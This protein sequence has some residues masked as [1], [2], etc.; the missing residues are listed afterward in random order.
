M[1]ELRRLAIGAL[2]A[3]AARA[4]LT[5]LILAKLRSDV[6]RLNGGD[7]AP[8][9]AGYADD[10]VLHFNDG[11]HRCAGEFRGKPAIEGFLRVF[12]DAGLQGEIPSLWIGGPPWALTIVA[13]FNDSATGPD[14]QQ[15]YA[16]EVVVVAKTK[17]GKIVDHQDF[18][19][20]TGRIL[21]FEQQL[22]ALGR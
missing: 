20:D 6:K 22:R 4:L 7:Y 17:W 5:R 15:L 3:V 8:L 16:N 10:A 19:V 13:R 1:V 12:A 2:T 21:E 11:D 18:Y 14:G 9:L